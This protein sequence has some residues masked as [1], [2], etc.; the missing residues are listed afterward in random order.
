MSF[1]ERDCQVLMM[2]QLTIVVAQES[3]MM[4]REKDEM[5]AEAKEGD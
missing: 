3:T 2:F 4:K 5:E 1:R